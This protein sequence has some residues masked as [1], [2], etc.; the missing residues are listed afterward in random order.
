MNSDAYFTDLEKWQRAQLDAQP[1]LKPCPFCG[2]DAHVFRVE[3]EGEEDAYFVGCD[4]V[5]TGCNVE[6]QTWISDDMGIV[7]DSWNQRIDNERIA[8]LEFQRDNLFNE[9]KALYRQLVAMKKRLDGNA[10]EE[11]H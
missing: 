2:G 6:V 1:E 7:I 4:G 10:T 5:E 9:N 3:G 8:D 11:T